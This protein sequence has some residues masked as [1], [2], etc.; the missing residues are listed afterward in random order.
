MLEHQPSP[1]QN[2]TPEKA[3]E[4]GT[5]FEELGVLPSVSIMKR[6]DNYNPRFPV[7]NH[8]LSWRNSFPSY[9]P[10]FAVE[11]DVSRLDAHTSELPVNP[12]G[13]TGLIGRGNL[14]FFG[15]NQAA[16]ALVTREVKGNQLEGLFIQ[17]QDGSWAFPGG[18][19]D[20]AEDAKTAMMRE[21]FEEAIEVNPHGKELLHQKANLL[22]QG[23]ADDP[24][25]TDNAWIETTA[26]SIHL[27]E[28]ESKE[29]TISARSD[30][31]K[32]AWK[33]LTGELIALL[34][35]FPRMKRG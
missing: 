24:R 3:R 31:Q 25:N 4:V 26:F 13:R 21:V 29:L 14:Y 8:L 16:D 10:N 22:Y 35:V 30:A 33:P 19:R 11:E 6:A 5:S 9:Q 20:G 12:A 28:E 27:T 32:V 2:T 34:N 7:P 18:F 17:R 1:R 15:A 23:Y